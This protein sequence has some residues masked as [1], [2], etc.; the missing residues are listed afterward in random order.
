MSPREFVKQKIPLGQGRAQ[1]CQPPQTEFSELNLVAA[2]SD[3]GPSD[4]KVEKMVSL[5]G[6]K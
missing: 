3:G 4:A 1:L 2:E 5:P 6:S